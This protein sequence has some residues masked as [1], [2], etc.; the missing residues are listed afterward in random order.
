MRITCSPYDRSE[1]QRMTRYAKGVRDTLIRRY[2][3]AKFSSDIDFCDDR[4]RYRVTVPA[5]AVLPV[6]VA[7]K[8]R[9]ERRGL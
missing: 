9:R 2:G 3:E 7:V 8:R 1:M 6:W 4:A 5:H